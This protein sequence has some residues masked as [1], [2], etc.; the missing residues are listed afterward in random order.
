MHLCC[1]LWVGGEGRVGE[2]VCGEG[3]GYIGEGVCGEGVGY[4]GEG[5]WWWSADEGDFVYCG[6][7]GMYIH[8]IGYGQ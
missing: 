1:F 8:V 2:G 5:V 6:S 7:G 4:I 3:V